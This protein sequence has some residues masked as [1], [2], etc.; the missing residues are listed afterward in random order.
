MRY[1]QTVR[2]VG[3][4]RVVAGARNVDRRR[5]LRVLVLCSSRTVYGPE[6]CVWQRSLP[7]VCS[8]CVPDT[9]RYQEA[10]HAIFNRCVCGIRSCELAAHF[11]E[12][13]YNPIRIAPAAVTVTVTVMAL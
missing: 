11:F 10:R 5:S 4:V 9:H 6:A 1:L 3:S 13:K 12:Q 2:P 7:R 8:A